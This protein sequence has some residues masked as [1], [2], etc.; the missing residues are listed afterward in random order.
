MRDAAA[1]IRARLLNLARAQRLEFQSVLT[2]YGIERLLYCLSVSPHVDRFVLKGAQ[3]LLVHAAEPHR[4]TKD[5]DLL[6]LGSDDTND[7]AQ[8]FREVCA[9]RVADDGLE[10][11]AG[12]VRAAVI[13]ETAR[14][15][16]VRVR[17]MATLERARIP[18][19]V[20]VGFGDVVMPAAELISF[21]V[22]LDGPVPTLQGYPL[23]TVVAEKLE[24]LT[25]LGLATS[26]MKDLYDLWYSLRTFE[27]READVRRGGPRFLD[28]L[29]RWEAGTLPGWRACEE[30]ASE[31][32][33][34]VQGEGC[35]G[36]CAGGSDDHGVEPQVRAA[37]EPDS[38]LEGAAALWRGRL[39]RFGCGAAA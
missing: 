29:A 33:S 14:Y 12:N 38:R 16:G 21:P 23:A 35:S 32:C 24:T 37:H 6:G 36:G 22:L 18:L 10:F 28:R 27:L 25:Q 1:S 2:R 17:L 8:V 15:G 7:V 19:Q 26:R 20:D 13:R 9:M 11:A 34:S 39:V 4:P 3:L 5:L 31:S 30:D